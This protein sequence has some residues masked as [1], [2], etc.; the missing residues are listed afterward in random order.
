MKRKESGFN[1]NGSWGSSGPDG[2]SALGPCCVQFMPNAG[3]LL[4]TCLEVVLLKE[5]VIQSTQDY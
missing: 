5:K 3:G 1:A 4:R 2:V